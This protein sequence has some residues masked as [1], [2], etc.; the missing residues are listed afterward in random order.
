MCAGLLPGLQPRFRCHPL[1]QAANFLCPCLF[2][3]HPLQPSEMSFALSMDGGKL[4]WGSHSLDTVFAQRSNLANPAFLRW[5]GAPAG[6]A[7]LQG[8]AARQQR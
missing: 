5:A 8:S 6:S 1:S 2:N 7:A 4:E 3:H